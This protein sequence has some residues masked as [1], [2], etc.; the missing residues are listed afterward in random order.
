MGTPRARVTGVCLWGG[1]TRARGGE[2]I[3]L[4]SSLSEVLAFRGACV[5]LPIPRKGNHL[6]PKSFPAPRRFLW[7][8]LFPGAQSHQSR[9]FWEDGNL[10][11][12]AVQSGRH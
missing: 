3:H 12:Y 6:F 1:C 2:C 10:D 11:I 4:R 7:L 5:P 8:L 9:T